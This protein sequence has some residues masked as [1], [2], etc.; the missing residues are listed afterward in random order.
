MMRSHKLRL[1]A[2][3]SFL[4]AASLQCGGDTTEPTTAAN[5][6]VV[7]GN[8][9]SAPA[10]ATLPSPL[11]VEVTDAQGDPVQGA[12]VQWDAD[13]VGTVSATTVRRGVKI[14]GSGS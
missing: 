13:G 10:G 12:T 8:G 4:A 3:A 5:I 1:A 9:Q 7:S 6:D 2:L 11:V 14:G